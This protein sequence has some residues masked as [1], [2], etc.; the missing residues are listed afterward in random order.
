LFARRKHL[1]SHNGKAKS[2]F[3]CNGG[4][5][6]RDTLLRHLVDQHGYDKGAAKE[7]IDLMEQSEAYY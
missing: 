7:L 1:D 6:R 4:Y 3:V 2:C 5:T